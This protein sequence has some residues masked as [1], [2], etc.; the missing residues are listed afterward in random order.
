MT[1]IMQS[2]EEQWVEMIGKEGKK[3]VG[4]LVGDIHHVDAHVLFAVKLKMCVVSSM[5]IFSCTF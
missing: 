3:R 1:Q 4:G 2:E 5:I